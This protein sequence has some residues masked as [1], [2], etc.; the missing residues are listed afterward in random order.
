MQVTIEYFIAFKRIEFK[1]VHTI[2]RFLAMVISSITFNLNGQRIELS[3]GEFNPS[4]TLAEFLR[5]DSI[6]LVGTKIACGEGGCGACTVV[7][8]TKN[9]NGNII[10]RAVNSCL[11]LM[12]QIHL[13]TITTI[14]FLGNL[15]DGVSAIHDSFVKHH[16]TQCGYC[17]P[18]FIMAAYAA[19]LNFNIH[20]LGDDSDQKK[21]SENKENIEFDIEDTHQ[22]DGNLCRC[23]GYRSIISALREFSNPENVSDE[24]ISFDETKLRKYN[25]NERIPV[26]PDYFDQLKDET[27]KINYKNS[28][29]FIPSNTE[30]L[31]R[32]KSECV[33][34]DRYSKIIVGSTE[35]SIDLS[36]KPIQSGQVY[37]STLHIEELS[38]VSIQQENNENY[39]FFGSNT[40][41][42]YI[43]SFLKSK[44]D[45]FFNKTKELN[46]FA[47]QL[48][49]R[50]EQFCSNQIRNLASVVGNIA[51]GGA[52]T[53]MSN[54]LLA[55]KALLVIKD[56]KSNE[57]YIKEMNNDFYLSYRKTSLK[58]S[59]I[60][61]AIKVALP[62][63]NEFVS[64]FKQGRRREDD[65][66]IV[67]STIFAR[68]NETSKIVD[69]R[70]AYS[71]MAAVPCRA[72][73]TE[74]F[75]I[76]KTFDL[77]NLHDS[78]AQINQQF[79]LNEETPGGLP[80]FRYDIAK[81]FILRFFHQTQRD[82]NLPFDQSAAEMIDSPPKKK[83]EIRG[84]NCKKEKEN[85][86]TS[87]STNNTNTAGESESNSA[88]KENDLKDGVRSEVGYPR[89]HL[90]AAQQTTGEAVYVDDMMVPQNTLH[91]AIVRSSIPHGRIISVDYSQALSISGV[92]AKIDKNDVIGPNFNGDIFTGEHVF[93]D[94]EVHFVGQV[95]A[96]IVA[97]DPRI[98]KEA[99][100]LVKIEYEELPAVLSINQSIERRSFYPYNNQIKDGDVSQLQSLPLTKNKTSPNVTKDGEKIHVIEGETFINGQSHF[101]FETCSALVEYHEDD[102]LT[103][104]TVTQNPSMVQNDIS[105]L[106]G[107]PAS[108]INVVIKRIGGAFGGKETRPAVVFNTTAIASFKL[109]RPV[110]TVLDR[111]EDM[112]TQGQ[113]HPVL[114]KYKVG[115]DD[116]GKIDS[117]ILD[118]Y[119]DCG[120]SLDMSAG[121]S[122][123][124]LL[125]ADSAYKIKNFLARGHLCRTNMIT[126][127]AFRG[128]GTPQAIVSME[129]IIK[130]I[131]IYL[132]KTPEEIQFVNLYRVQQ[133]IFQMHLLLLD[134]LVLILMEKLL[135]MHVS[136]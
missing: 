62:K 98:A 14:E 85:N 76:G 33:D 53:D 44:K 126:S 117:I 26:V 38:H 73:D 106:T 86:K 59:E 67:S 68:I 136:N 109:K 115:F 4:Q 91:A 88:D 105:R 64:T 114:T 46:R 82:R 2:R 81:G 90:S 15:R 102:N 124:L 18:G 39:L 87:T 128:F 52:A 112:S 9:K 49:Q 28:T 121:V 66:C 48:I 107:I 30:E 79:V 12:I 122:D 61:T 129:T 54:F 47:N 32:I 113:R 57:T 96:L 95:I 19:F 42:N 92:I 123:R 56:V 17:T 78:F 119:L 7:M 125:H 35:I 1:F 132:G 34:N 27:V 63:E 11:I 40:P 89:H 130:N 103:V 43:L 127:T 51:H 77:S 99:A 134:Q 135:K 74:Q 84:C 3:E 133:I 50:I 6:H 100:K 41:L 83:F 101:Y 131:S 21:K 65:I 24:S 25:L 72:T 22:L 104:F 111:H 120:F 10:H 70:I 71:G 75:L 29:F 5:S 94:D 16:A 20:I 55:M 58:N 93:A 36:N 23:T 110:K 118:Y 8:S 97:K 31:F 13:T 45:E 37:I 108:K 116:T 69:I 60:I 80:Q